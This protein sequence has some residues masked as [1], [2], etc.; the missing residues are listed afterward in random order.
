MLAREFASTWKR[1]IE[2]INADV[3]KLFED[4]HN[5]TE[6]LKQVLT[7]LLL[8]YTRFQVREGASE[9]ANERTSGRAP[10]AR[11]RT[12][13]LGRPRRQLLTLTYLAFCPWLIAR[14]REHAPPGHRADSMAEQSV[15][16]GHRDHVKYL[17]RDQ[18]ILG[19]LIFVIFDFERIW[20]RPNKVC[21]RVAR[22]QVRR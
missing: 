6:L 9:R 8:Y 5:G 4:V 7:Q 3:G 11:A 15:C 17:A 21:T 13:C 1:G 22:V 19:Q 16:E 12:P 2:L 20:P 18:T 14:A 10:R